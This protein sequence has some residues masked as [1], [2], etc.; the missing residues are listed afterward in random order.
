MAL[1]DIGDTISA[2]GPLIFYVYDDNGALANATT[3]T[4]TITLPD[5]TTT[6]PTDANPATGTYTASYTPAVAGTFYVRWVAEDVASVS[7]ADTV[8]EDSFTVSASSNAF[9]SLEEAKAYTNLFDTA[10]DA[11]L[12]AYLE[13]AC[14]LAER[15]ADTDFARKTVTAETHS[16]SGSTCSIQ[17]RRR[18][19]LSVTTVT[20][21]GATLSA[22]GYALDSRWGTLYRQA[23]SYTDTTWST[24][25]NVVA[26]TYVVGY[27]IIPPE[28]R[29]A[30][31]QILEHL[32]QNQRGGNPLAGGF[33]GA[34]EFPNPGANWN[35]PN[36]ARDT[37][38]SYAP[39]LVG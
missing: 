9:V 34:D 15:I 39:P 32:W 10:D 25:R 18:P 4:C 22:S 12:E 13:W 31:L 23:G 6:S 21:A 16:V 29:Q 3:V 17:L 35:V 24:G 20:E 30:T 27:A 11:E 7:G 2:E 14:T 8:S 28:V 36:K 26:V 1:Y 19:V 33:R 37:L 5:G 38:L